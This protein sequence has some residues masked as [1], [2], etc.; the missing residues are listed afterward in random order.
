[1]SQESELDRLR[2]MLQQAQHE[3]TTLTYLEVAN[4]MAMEPPRRIHRTTQ[5]I[6][7][8]LNEDIRAG[9]PP[10]AALVVSR[11]RDGLPAPGFFDRARRLGMDVGD[12]PGRFHQ[13]LL[14]QI[15]TQHGPG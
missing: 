3:R 8:L 12:D 10:L 4:R 11:I 5:L 2:S 9:R 15:Y 13:A 6:E 7:R 1:M 14:E